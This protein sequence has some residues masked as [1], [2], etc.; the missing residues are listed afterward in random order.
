M[1]TKQMA[2]L[3]LFY[4]EEAIL[5]VLETEPG[6]LPPAEIGNRIGI[7]RYP[8]P[9]NRVDRNA[10]LYGILVKLLTEGRVESVISDSNIRHWKLA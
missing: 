6:G 7:G 8:D 1:T 3:G 9:D 10:L 4:I 5:E 2:R